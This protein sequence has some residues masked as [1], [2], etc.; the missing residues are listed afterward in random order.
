[1]K[2]LATIGALSLCISC[3]SSAPDMP[4]ANAQ[5][6]NLTPGM[7]KSNIKEGQTTQTQVLQVFGAPNIVTM[8]TTGHEVWTYDVQS[9]QYTS[10]Q[11]SK[12]GGGGAGVAAA[13]VAN[14]TLVGGG[15]AAGGAGSKNT[16]VGASTSSTFTLMITFRDNGTVDNYRMM[17]T[18][19]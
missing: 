19:F 1:M 13:G 14:S 10:A 15:A 4:A 6:S 7:V 16:N 9:T 11:T 12:S 2:I 8:D 18:S 3:T 17:S 5:K